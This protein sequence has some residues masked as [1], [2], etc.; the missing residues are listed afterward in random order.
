MPCQRH[1]AFFF[2]GWHIAL[3]TYLSQRKCP[4]FFSEKSEKKNKPELYF[5]FCQVL[6]FFFP[7]KDDGYLP[8]KK[9]QFFFPDFLDEKK[10]IDLP[11]YISRIAPNCHPG[12][13]KKLSAFGVVSYLPRDLPSRWRLG[14]SRIRI[15]EIL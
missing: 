9:C 5:N 14:L 3:P 2:P 8:P 11:T 4:L 7:L 1:S 6:V 10:K 13:K 15:Q 12:K